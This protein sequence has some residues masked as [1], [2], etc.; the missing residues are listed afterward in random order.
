VSLW[1]SKRLNVCQAGRHAYVIRHA[2][3]AQ[4]N[5]ALTEFPGKRAQ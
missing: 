1:P 5:Q 3:R 2:K 4:V